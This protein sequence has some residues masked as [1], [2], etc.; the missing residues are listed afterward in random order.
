MLNLIGTAK[1]IPVVKIE[2]ADDAVPMAKALLAAGLSVAEVTFRTQAAASAILHIS[3]ACPEMTILAGTVLNVEQAKLAVASGAK[4]I[5]S[6]GL[7]A[8]VVEWC[9][10]KGIPVCPGCATPTEVEHAMRMGLS[11][12]KLF[13]AEV[14][15]G[16]KMLKALHGPYHAMKFMPTGGI[17]ADSALEYLKQPNVICIGGSWICTE[18]MLAEKDFQQIEATAKAAVKIT[19]QYEKIPR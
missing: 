19:E 8:D 4:G 3:K 9:Q 12:V 1:I 13:P 5:V 18:K 14:L 6:P 10:A 15:G 11:F 16:E 2:N 17:T 7:N